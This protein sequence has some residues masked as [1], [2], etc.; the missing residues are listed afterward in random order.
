MD[1]RSRYATILGMQA[2]WEVERVELRETEQAVHVWVH[3]APGTGFGC[4]EC[5]AASPT[6][7]PVERAVRR[8]LLRRASV[9][10]RRLGIDEHSHHPGP[11]RCTVLPHD[12][13]HHRPLPLSTPP[14]SHPPC[15]N[16]PDT[17]GSCPYQ[18]DSH[19]ADSDVALAE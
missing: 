16:Y 5:A 6:Y 4:P 14:D 11:E 8:G 7:D 2:P 9:A 18:T 15:D 3:E 12:H 1:D 10:G 17:G 13:T 19:I